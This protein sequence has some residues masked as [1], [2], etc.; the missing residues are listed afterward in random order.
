ML[1]DKVDMLGKTVDKLEYILNIQEDTVKT[2]GN[3]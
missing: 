3:T 2:L 1:R